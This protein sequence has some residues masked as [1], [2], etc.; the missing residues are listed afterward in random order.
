[1]NR[2]FLL[3]LLLVLAPLRAYT[4]TCDESITATAPDSRYLV[5]NNTNEVFDTETRLTWQKC[6][7][8]QTGS[9]CSGESKYYSFLE[10]S[11]SS[12]NSLIPDDWRLPTNNELKSL[13][14]SKCNA[15]AIN[16]IVFPNTSSSFYWTTTYSG[17][18]GNSTGNPV[19]LYYALSFSNKAN[20]L[21]QDYSKQLSRLVRDDRNASTFLS[22]TAPILFENDFS[23]YGY[24]KENNTGLENIE[25][26]T[27]AQDGSIR[28]TF[29][30]ADGIYK[31]AL[32]KDWT[33][34][35]VPKVRSYS[36]TPQSVN[37]E[38]LADNTQLDFIAEAVQS[39]HDARV[40]MVAAN[41]DNNDPL[42]PYITKEANYAYRVLLKKGISKD[43]IRYYN[44][45]T[46]QDVD[47]N[48]YNDDIEGSPSNENIKQSIT[49]WAQNY[50]TEKRPL[51]IYL[52]GHGEK[53]T[54]YI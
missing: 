26:I 14:E 3:I 42:Q 1:M 37:I 10:L 27:K 48:Q 24:V 50:V 16:L 54:F 40:L 17:N 7:L 21:F 31:I 51:I 45:N 38:L 32:W 18:S 46:E 25:V 4:Q 47:E 5:N 41:V 2:N 6:S 39:E 15:P 19:D 33:G 30:D 28:S 53:D 34:I 11:S 9:D 23:V 29:T 8:G 22:N 49:K 36:F 12:A 20:Y 52:L 43:N 13:I 35:I 44:A